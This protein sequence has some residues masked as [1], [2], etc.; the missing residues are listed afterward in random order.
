MR[1]IGVHGKARSGKD[2]LCTTLCGTYGFEKVSFANRVKKFGIKY[3]GLTHEN[4]YESKTKES[5][6]ILQGIGN[7]VRNYIHTN[8]EDINGVSTYPLWVEEIAVNEFGIETVDLKGKKKLIKTVLSGIFNLWKD[9]IDEF[10][11]FCGNDN[12]SYWVN[13]LLQTL[14][15]DVVYIISDVRYKN[16][17]KMIVD[18]KGKSVKIIRVDKPAIEY[19][20]KHPT[21]TDLDDDHNWNFIIVN[22]QI[23]DWR[24]KL[25]AISANMVRKFMNENFFEGKDIEKFLVNLS[26]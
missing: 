9:N 2:E 17:K 4:C 12:N 7:S 3:F 8:K 6:Q 21:E 18:H 11:Q 25:T 5:R 23:K 15:D 1:L 10:K 19:G 24:E 20:E 14:K 26:V 16:E 22:D 13:Y